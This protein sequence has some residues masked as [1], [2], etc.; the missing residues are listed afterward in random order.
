MGRVK[1]TAAMVLNSEY[2]IISHYTTFHRTDALGTSAFRAL[3]HFLPL[4]LP[5]HLLFSVSSSVIL[6]T[7]DRSGRAE[8]DTERGIHNS[9]GEIQ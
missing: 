7:A 4:S 1:K 2:N 3:P 6:F 8:E 5:H 9:R